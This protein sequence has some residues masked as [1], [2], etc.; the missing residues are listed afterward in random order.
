MLLRPIGICVWLSGNDY[1]IQNLAL[2]GRV[3]YRCLIFIY[4]RG[5]WIVVV[6][7]DHHGHQAPSFTHLVLASGCQVLSY[8]ACRGLSRCR[9]SMYKF[10]NGQLKALTMRSDEQ[11][12][13]Y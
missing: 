13:L 7:L 4:S 2:V 3:G 5:G 6:A 11:V 9:R 1:A 10:R 12:L 8:D